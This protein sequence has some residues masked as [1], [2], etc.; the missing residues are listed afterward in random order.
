MLC[1]KCVG[2]TYT[3]SFSKGYDCVLLNDGAA[4]TSPEYAQQCFQYNAANTW[5]FATSCRDFAKGVDAMA[6]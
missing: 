3:D 4:T 5:G 2:G 1:W 6:V